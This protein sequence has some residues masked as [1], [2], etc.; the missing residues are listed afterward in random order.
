MMTY[1]HGQYTDWTS[2]YVRHFHTGYGIFQDTHTYGFDIV[3]EGTHLGGT[4]PETKIKHVCVLAQNY[5]HCFT[6]R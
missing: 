3:F 4:A 2:S 5:Q 1:E 6:N